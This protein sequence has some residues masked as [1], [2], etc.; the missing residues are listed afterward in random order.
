MA[1]WHWEKIWS[2]LRCLYVSK[3]MKFGQLILR[4][5]IKI[6]ITRCQILRL[7]CAKFDFG[8]GS[9]LDLAG[10]A[11][12]APRDYSSHPPSGWKSEKTWERPVN[13]F[14]LPPLPLPCPSL[15]SLFVP[16][17]S[18]LWLPSLRPF[19]FSPSLFSLPFPK[20]RP[21]KSSYGFWESAVSSSS[22]IWDGSP[23]EIELG[24]FQPQNLTFLW[25]QQFQ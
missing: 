14:V 17:T 5:I 18:L 9:N 6:F 4:K 25:W 16:S 20:S 21:L 2:R 22:G 11:Y 23:A 13:C 19:P 7:K 24:A 15:P 3:C 1:E 8:W 10:R 12:S